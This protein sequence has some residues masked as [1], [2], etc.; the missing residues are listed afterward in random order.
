MRISHS[1]Y[2]SGS[3]SEA[4]TTQRDLVKDRFIE[5]LSEPHF[6]M[7]LFLFKEPVCPNKNDRP[8]FS[9]SR[10]SPFLIRSTSMSLVVYGLPKFIPSV[11]V[12]VDNLKSHNNKNEDI[13]SEKSRFLPTCTIFRD[14]RAA[15]VRQTAR[16]EA[17]SSRK[18][19]LSIQTQGSGV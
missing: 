1:D 6:V 11:V 5:I 3:K 12:E 13:I 9:I 14:S 7:D 15:S 17:E 10:R 18:R 4:R 19:R 2:G 16:R 8:D